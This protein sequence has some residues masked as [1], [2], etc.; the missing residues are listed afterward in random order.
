[1]HVSITALKCTVFALV[2]I[3]LQHIKQLTNEVAGFFSN[4]L[5]K[6]EEVGKHFFLLLKMKK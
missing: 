6:L 4:Y 2:A 3:W 1:V 5:H